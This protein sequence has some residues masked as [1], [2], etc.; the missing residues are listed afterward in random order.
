MDGLDSI[1]R[2]I[3][4]ASNQ[5]HCFCD[6][7]SL[8]VHRCHAQPHR[9]YSSSRYRTPISLW[10][11]PTEVVGHDELTWVVFV[12]REVAWRAGAGVPFLFSK[13]AS[14]GATRRSSSR[15]K[16]QNGSLALRRCS[17]S[18]RGSSGCSGMAWWLGGGEK[19]SWGTRGFFY[20]SRSPVGRGTMPRIQSYL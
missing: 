5:S 8:A 2:N 19:L 3:F 20:R 7:R 10:F 6:G 12:A 16:G 13:A 4:Q 15:G 1:Q 14:G 17:P 11:I 9:R 18:Q